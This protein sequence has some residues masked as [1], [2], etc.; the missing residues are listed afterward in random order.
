MSEDEKNPSIDELVSTL[1]DGETSDFEL[2]RVLKETGA[3]DEACPS[4]T[5]ER[6]HI[7]KAAMLKDLP[8]SVGSDI[9]ARVSDAI[10]A[11]AHHQ[12]E[13]ESTESI[14]GGTNGFHRFWR[15]IV[16]IAVAASVAVAIIFV[17]E[18]SQNPSVQSA[19]SPL[20][21]SSGA[22]LPNLR[23]S[24]SIV[25]YSAA[26]PQVVQ[27]NGNQF[28]GHQGK[29]SSSRQNYFETNNLELISNRPLTKPVADKSILTVQHQQRLNRYFVTHTSHAALSTNSGMMPYVRVVD[30]PATKKK[31]SE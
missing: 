11:E 5:W 23:P 25:N 18:N 28:Y 8:D 21:Q 10:Q 14:G 30:M 31:L 9:S 2:R 27:F 3:D 29:A 12:L 4:R 17:W 19:A 15:P 13:D 20:A 24:E 1:M 7:I 26:G 16:N 6:Y 22:S